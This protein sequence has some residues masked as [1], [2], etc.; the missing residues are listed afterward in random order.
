MA[1]TTGDASE[2]HSVDNAEAGV[3]G[4][5]APPREASADELEAQ[6]ASAGRRAE[7][8]RQDVTAELTHGVNAITGEEEEVPKVA[9]GNPVPVMVPESKGTIENDVTWPQHVQ[10]PPVEQVAPGELSKRNSSTSQRRTA[11]KRAASK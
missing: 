10:A 3:A 11:A 9:S 1:R 4:P 2:K 5:D 8:V 7:N 6:K